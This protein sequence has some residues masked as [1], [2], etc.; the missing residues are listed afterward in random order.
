MNPNS[1]LTLTK[2]LVN[3]IR[4]RVDPRISTPGFV[5]WIIGNSM[6]HHLGVQGTYNPPALVLFCSQE[7]FEAMRLDWRDVCKAYFGSIQHNG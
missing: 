5:V 2:L 3:T 1:I 7:D 6:S 4:V